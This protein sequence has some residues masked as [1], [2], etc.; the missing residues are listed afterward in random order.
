[1]GVRSFHAPENFPTDILMVMF[2]KFDCCS[3]LNPTANPRHVKSK[4]FCLSGLTQ[5]KKPQNEIGFERH[6]S[7]TG[8]SPGL[9][10]QL[11]ISANRF[12]TKIKQFKALFFLKQNRRL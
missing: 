1:M 7:G 4:T 5:N 10:D 2:M 11:K 9:S 6:K 3:K 8:E 12:T